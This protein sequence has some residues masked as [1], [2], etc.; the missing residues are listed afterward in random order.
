MNG[1]AI[2]RASCQGETK[3]RRW[4]PGRRG[5]TLPA[6]PSP[7]NIHAHPEDWLERIER[8]AWEEALATRAFVQEF[9]SPGHQDPKP[10]IQTVREPKQG[11]VSRVACAPYQTAELFHVQSRTPGHHVLIKVG[12]LSND[13]L[14]GL[15]KRC[16]RWASWFRAAFRWHG[17]QLYSG[18]Q[19][20]K[21]A[22]MPYHGCRQL[23]EPQF[24]SF[25]VS[26]HQQQ[27]QDL[28]RLGEAIRL[29][30]EQH[31][32]TSRALAEATRTPRKTLRDLEAGRIDPEFD[33]LLT[34]ADGLGVRPSAFIVRAEELEATREK[35]GE[36]G[37]GGA[38]DCQEAPAQ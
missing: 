15:A 32:M 35:P 12:V 8:E 29:V 38:S 16:V 25:S 3:G 22:S 18:A 10:G 23:S 9:I 28:A 24:G 11:A 34:L 33:L 30:R 2:R 5:P 7:P 20:N 14:N 19:K 26:E 17:Q 6:D 36:P 27:E 21:R 37:A 31:S 4:Q 13:Y 1:R